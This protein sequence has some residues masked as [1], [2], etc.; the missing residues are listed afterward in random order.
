MIFSF[1]AIPKSK[2]FDNL[3]TLEQKALDNYIK[4]NKFT[5]E[6]EKIVQEC[7]LFYKNSFAYLNTLPLTKFNNEDAKKVW[8]YLNNVFNFKLIVENDGNF[9]V[10]FRVTVVHEIFR[11]KGKVRNP[12]YLY[13][14]PLHINQKRGI[15]NRCNSPNSTAF[16]AA[17][18]ENVALRE[19]KPQKGDTIIITTWKN[20]DGRH[21]VS[22][23]ISNALLTNNIG[24]AKATNALE[25]KMANHHPL[26]KEHFETI[27]KFI[28]SEFVK[29]K[30]VISENKFEYL[31]S[32]FF[33]EHIL[34]ENNPQ[35]PAP[36]FDFIVYP[37]VAYKHFEDNICV[38]E[39][40]LH[41]LKPVYLQEFEI[42]DTYY[43][44]PLT[45]YDPPANLRAIREATWITDDLIIWEDE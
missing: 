12:K 1:P 34:K 44:S 18:Y 22:Y 6:E 40:S 31:F 11:E 37:S 2:V 21:F 27:L 43:D 25:K 9:N 13:N 39:R 35:D 3:F 24:N 17:F 15:Y 16:Y 10:V 38:P 23:P 20:I 26:F 5:D 45:L 28:S 30:E 41:R 19:T 4:N 33:S 42:L 7:I 32:A 14:P 29:D 8:D 36:N